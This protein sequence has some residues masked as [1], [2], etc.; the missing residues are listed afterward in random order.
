MTPEADLHIYRAND[1][2]SSAA[3]RS[4][5]ASSTALA[6]GRSSCAPNAPKGGGEGGLDILHERGNPK[7]DSTKEIL[8]RAA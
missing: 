2:V 4:N 8:W 7:A 3:L 6:P 1:G 5:P